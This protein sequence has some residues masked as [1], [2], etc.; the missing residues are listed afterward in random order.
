MH[1]RADI[2]PSKNLSIRHPV[3]LFNTFGD[4]RFKILKL[5]NISFYISVSSIVYSN[6]GLAGAV[7]NVIGKTRND[8]PGEK[9]SV[10]L[11]LDISF[12]S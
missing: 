3:D 7:K 5:S 12:P 4:K 11:L 10:E 2:L 8:A 1:A 9:K 6:S